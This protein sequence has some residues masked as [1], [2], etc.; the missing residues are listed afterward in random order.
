M[1]D[2]DNIL[3]E[4]VVGAATG[5]ATGAISG[6]WTWPGGEFLS[7]APFSN[8]VSAQKLTKQT[9]HA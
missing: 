7:D 3:T 1:A 4:M 6:A 5:A 2:K 8:L 9:A